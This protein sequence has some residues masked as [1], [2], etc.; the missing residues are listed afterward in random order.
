MEEVEMEYYILKDG[1]LYHHGIKGQ[2][3]GRRR[4]QNPDGS[5]TPAGEKRYNKYAEKLNKLDDIRSKTNARYD[6]KNE[7]AKRKYSGG[8]LKKIIAKNDAER[9]FIITNNEEV[10]ARYK[11]KLDPNYKKSDEYAKVKYEYGK[12]QADQILYGYTG[13][14]K[15]KTLQ[16]LGKTEQ[17]AHGQVIA[18]TILKSAAYIAAIE[19]IYRVASR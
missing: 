1:E 3:W 11:A 17:Q 19:A 2:K 18:E 16:K 12:Q 5:L 4:F 10:R 6:R 14:K 7:A 13:A 8:K 15:I 9:D